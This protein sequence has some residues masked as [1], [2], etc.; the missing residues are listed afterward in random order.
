MRR[1]LTLIAVEKKQIDI[2]TMIEFMTP[3]FAQSNN[4]KLSARRAEIFAE[5]MVPMLENFGDANLCELG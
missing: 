1:K 4:R 2:G 5:L 3:E